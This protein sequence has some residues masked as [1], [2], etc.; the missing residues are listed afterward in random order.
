MRSLGRVLRSP[1]RPPATPSCT[2]TPHGRYGGGVVVTK[3]PGWKRWLHA[4]CPPVSHTRAWWAAARGCPG[5]Q[6]VGFP[7]CVR[8]FSVCRAAGCLGAARCGAGLQFR[9]GSDRGEATPLLGKSRV[10]VFR[11]PAS[12]WVISLWSAVCTDRFRTQVLAPGETGGKGHRRR[13]SAVS[14]LGLNG[15]TEERATKGVHTAG[16]SHQLPRPALAKSTNWAAEA[17][18]ACPLTVPV[19]GSPRSRCGRGH[20][21]R[22]GLGSW[23]LCEL[24]A[25]PCLQTA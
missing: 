6:L 4:C 5:R 8:Q 18:E 25:A 1:H 16:D 2:W 17:A 3:G 14:F 13:N 19:D 24:L 21:G 10:P 23:L 20:E 12:G 11:R 7:W 22:C 15:A 9:L